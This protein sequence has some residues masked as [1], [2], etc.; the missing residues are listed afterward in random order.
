MFL[1]LIHES[2]IPEAPS[3]EAPSL[4]APSTKASSPEAPSPEAPKPRSPMPHQ[5]VVKKELSDAAPEAETK[6]APANPPK[7]V[8]K[9]ELGSSTDSRSTVKGP[10]APAVTKKKLGAGAP[11]QA[12]RAGRD[13]GNSASFPLLVV[14][15]ELPDADSSEAGPLSSRTRFSVVVTKKRKGLPPTA[16]S[17]QTL[18]GTAQSIAAN[19]SAP[20]LAAAAPSPGVVK[21]AQGAVPPAATVKQEPGGRPLPAR[22]DS[23]QSYRYRKPKEA[24]SCL[25]AP[26]VQKDP[27][28]NSKYCA[29]SQD[30]WHAVP[31]DIRRPE[32]VFD[33]SC[34]S[35][36]QNWHACCP[37]LRRECEEVGNNTL[38][39]PRGRSPGEARKYQ[40]EPGA[41][42]SHRGATGARNSQGGTRRSQGARRFQRGRG[43]RA[44]GRGGRQEQPGTSPPPA[45]PGCFLVGCACCLNGLPRGSQG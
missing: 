38:G 31:D 43:A 4:E 34:D 37:E 3:P 9:K 6:A 20:T 18:A 13:L 40:E 35:D 5:L 7:V 11:F 42:R 27:R 2:P 28:P 8:V 32:D 22:K 26:L 12:A 39:R 36:D 15:K 21:N 44:R 33:D 24:S 17:G 29:R 16:T 19:S 45:L 25:R 1:A 30:K 14:K 23:M 41:R 10:P